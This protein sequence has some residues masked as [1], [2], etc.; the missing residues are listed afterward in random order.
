MKKS[1]LRQLIREELGK[2][3]EVE[4]DDSIKQLL[5]HHNF[6][7]SPAP[8]DNEF[9]KYNYTAIVGRNGNVIITQYTPNTHRHLDSVTF[10]NTDATKLKQYL[11]KNIPH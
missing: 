2:L 6:K 5:Q 1:E 9:K 8:L 3:N 7:Q 10:K 4:V 11:E